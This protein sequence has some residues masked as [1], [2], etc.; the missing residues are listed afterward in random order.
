MKRDKRFKCMC[1][2]DSGWVNDATDDG[3]VIDRECDC[4]GY[5]NRQ[6][7]ELFGLLEVARSE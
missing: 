4:L 2:R 1:C 3:G 6:I 5:A 7:D